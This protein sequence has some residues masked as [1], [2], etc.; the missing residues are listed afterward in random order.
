MTAR[1]NSLLGPN[2][3]SILAVVLIIAFTAI[4]LWFGTPEPTNGQTFA[5]VLRRFGQDSKTRTILAFILVDV[6]LGVMCALRLR[7][8]DIQRLATFYASNVL[9]YILGYLLVWILVLLG[10]DGFLPPMIQDGIAS[11]GFSMIVTTLTGSII[12]NLQRMTTPLSFTSTDT[13]TASN[14]DVNSAKG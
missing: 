11:L 9:P 12:D 5:D 4:G 1:H 6:V 2:T 14:V 13:T 3:Y 8:F 7:I 10:L